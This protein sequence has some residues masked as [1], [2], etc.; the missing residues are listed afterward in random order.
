VRHPRLPIVYFNEQSGGDGKAQGGVQALAVDAASGRVTKLSDVRAGG[1]GTT[2]LWLDGPS[3]TLLAANYSS[4]SLAT[5][6]VAADGT[7]ATISSLVSFVGSG[8]NTTRQQSPHPHDVSLDPTGHWALVTDL[9]ADRI[10]VLPFDRQTGRLHVH[11]APGAGP[12][13]MAWH[14]QGRW[15]Y[16]VDELTARIDTYGWDSAKGE[17]RLQQS[18]ALDTPGFAGTPSASEVVMSADGRF[19]Y[20]GNRGEH[21]LVALRADAKTGQ[22]T[23]IQQIAS[24][25]KLPWH[26]TLD[27]SGQWLLVSNRD[28]NTI[29]IFGRDAQTGLLANTGRTVSTPQPVFAVFGPVRAAPAK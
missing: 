9:G 7:L 18:L 21:S 6:P 16:V 5:L 28:S 17:L 3:S 15:L 4:G 19:V 11:V 8:P 23:Q 25:G 26:F 27:E 12:R 1:G 13:H 24:G 14:P 29:A 22:L 2:L 10:W 20:V